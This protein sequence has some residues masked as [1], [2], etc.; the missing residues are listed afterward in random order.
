MTRVD[1]DTYTVDFTRGCFRCELR[2]RRH[3]ITTTHTV[4]YGRS[5][6]FIVFREVFFSPP[7]LILPWSTPTPTTRRR[8]ASFFA[9][10]LRRD[11]R[12]AIPKVC[13]CATPDMSTAVMSNTSMFDCSEHLFKVSLV[14]FNL[15]SRCVLC[16]INVVTRRY[17]GLRSR[18]S[19]PRK[20]PVL[21]VNCSVLVKLSLER[22]FG[23]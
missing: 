6:S 10:P 9:R 16:F 19:S 12:T 18:A 17:L 7:P 23:T 2:R 8:A 4:A 22:K 3:R 11:E 21:S 15:P 1:R 14:D 13:F 20:K 5:G